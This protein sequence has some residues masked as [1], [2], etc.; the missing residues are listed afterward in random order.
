MKFFLIGTGVSLIGI[1]LSIIIWDVHMISTI[2]SRIGFI[3]LLWH[4]F[5]P[6]H[7]SMVTECGQTQQWKQKKVGFKEMRLHGVLLIWQFPTL[8]LHLSF[9]TI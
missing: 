7:S 1:L 4:A 8:P 2:T 3:F 6:G 9:T 5:F